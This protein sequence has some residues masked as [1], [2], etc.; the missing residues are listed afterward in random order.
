MLEMNP[1]VRDLWVAALRSGDYKQGRGQLRKNDRYC[2]LG[3]LCDLHR[4][5]TGLG[6]W[7]VD[8]YKTDKSAAGIRDYLPQTVVQWAGLEERNSSVDS[9]LRETNPTVNGNALS[10][11]NDDGSTFAQIA[12]LIAI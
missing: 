1:Q 5:E 2:C 3:V 4:I 12:D 10:R 6:K 7:I 9:F 8:T 11:L